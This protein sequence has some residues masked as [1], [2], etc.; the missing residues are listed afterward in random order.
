MSSVQE[1]LYAQV[2]IDQVSNAVDRPFQYLVPVNLHNIITV[3]SRVTAPFRSRKVTAYVV[4]LEKEAAVENPR[5][6]AGLSDPP[7]TLLP[8]FVKLSYWVS[9]RFFSRWIEAIRLC[10]PPAG[11]RLKTKHVEYVYPRVTVRALQEESGQLKKRAPRQSLIL[12]HLARSGSQGLPWAQLREKTGASRSS[13]TSLEDKELVKVEKIPYGKLPMQEPLALPDSKTGLPFSSQQA[14][15]WE[16]IEKG[17]AGSQKQFLIHGVTGSGKT[18]LYLHTAGE[19]LKQGRTVLFLVPEIMLTPQIINHFN[20][21]FTGQFALLHS[22][23]SPGERYREWKRIEGGQ[24]RFVLGARSA[25]FAPLKDIGLI[26]MDE[27]H[28][29]TYKQDDAPRYHTRDVAQWRATFHGALLLLGSATPALETYLETKKQKIKL[30]QLRERIGGRP[31]PAV[32]LVDMRREFKQKNRGIFSRLLLRAMKET[33]SRKEQ[34]ILFLNRRGFASFQLC[35]ECGWVI[36]CPNCDVSLTFH[37][38]PER[39]LCHYCGYKRAVPACCPRCKSRYIRN[40]GLGTQ[41][42]EKEVRNIFPGSGVLRMD[43]DITGTK[44][45]YEKIWRS[46]QEKKASILIGTQMVAKG[47]DFPDV[48][49]VG[50]IAADIALHLPDFR[51]GERTFQLL[52]QVAGRAGRGEKEGQVIVQTYT[53]WH[54][55]IQAAARHDY[56]T[57]TQEE[58]NRRQLLFYPP[59]ADLILI[60][61]SSPREHEARQAAAGLRKRMVAAGLPLAGEEKGEFLGPSPAPLHRIKGRFRYHLLYKGLDLGRYRAR[62]REVVWAFTNE[63]KSDTWVTVDFNPLKML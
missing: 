4:A 42:V 45:A 59:F 9:Q 13:L 32:H 28:E 54:Y 57:F 61:C 43:S 51:A 18:K 47:L 16:E 27:E 11:S 7:F 29:N 53:P 46:F 25:V 31:L 50:V 15:V 52:T 33:L 23:L 35:R 26:I 55:S 22:N 19:V 12:A 2:I 36:Q 56:L 38:A 58:L 8:E 21:L 44:G 17:F 60:C 37:A 41:Q 1:K 48:T 49:L 30:L 6:I 14:A 5:E 39:L 40:F 34:L 62:I 63:V 24:A 10:L 3:G 20:R